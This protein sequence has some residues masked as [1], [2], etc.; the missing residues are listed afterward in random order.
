L[1]PYKSSCVQL[2]GRQA[3][4]QA[5]QLASRQADRQT[6]RKAGTKASRSMTDLVQAEQVINFQF[7]LCAMRQT[8]PEVAPVMLQTAK[9]HGV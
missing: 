8:P 7:L 2:A 4:K 6:E 1:I 3:G 9:L 5:S